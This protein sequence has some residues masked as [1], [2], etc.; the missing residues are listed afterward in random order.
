MRTRSGRILNENSD[1]QC[2]ICCCSSQPQH[3]NNDQ[4][5]CL[6]NVYV[7]LNCGHRFHDM[8]I[9]KSCIE[10]DR[11]CPLCRSFISMKRYKQIRAA[12]I[13]RVVNYTSKNPWNVSPIV[14]KN[15]WKYKRLLKKQKNHN[16]TKHAWFHS[17]DG[18]MYRNLRIIA[19]KLNMQTYR[20]TRS[21]RSIRYLILFHTTIASS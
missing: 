16:S 18:I 21:I 2:A 3:H 6:H 20:N 13:R 5:D 14:K 10:W 15:V 7:T 19:H 1:Q 17:A 8:C 11:L 4:T 9:V 12:R